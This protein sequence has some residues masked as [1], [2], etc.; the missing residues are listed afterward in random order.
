MTA[1]L[2]P[3]VIGMWAGVCLLLAIAMA[4]LNWGLRKAHQQ[5]LSQHLQKIINQQRGK[6]SAPLPELMGIKQPLQKYAK[7]QQVWLQHLLQTVRFNTWAVDRKVAAALL[8]FGMFL[9]AMAYAHGGAVGALG[10]V[11][12]YSL[13]IA[14]MLW[15]RL[16]KI[17]QKMLLQLPA[18]IDNMVR[19]ITLGTSTQAAFQMA[20]FSVQAPLGPELEKA[21]AVLSANAD[22][23]YAMESLEKSWGL[24]EFGLLGAVFRMSVK[25]GGRADLVLERVAAYVRDRQSADRELHAL[26]SEVRMSAW[27]LSL[28]PIVVGA[29]I[30][31]LNEGYFLNLWSDAGGRKIIAIA[32]SLELLGVVFLYRLARLR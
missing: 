15:R 28:L 30:M 20:V 4:L 21:S 23:G 13:F 8:G 31:V 11:L 22:L 27:I 10:I 2:P 5:S 25:Y 19:L 16:Q 24:P 9:I 29:G 12:A 3:I 18:F 26:S 32:A 6:L 17:R 7:V 14:F 1:S